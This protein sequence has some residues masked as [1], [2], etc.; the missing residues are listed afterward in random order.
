MS[1]ENKVINVKLRKFDMTNIGDCKVILFIGKRNTGKSQLVLDYLYHNRDIPLGTIISP[2]DDYNFTYK[3]HVPSIFI[4]ENFDKELINHVL[5]RQK[6]MCK[7][8]QF[9]SSYKN[10]DPRAFLIFDDC[11]AGARDWINDKNIRWIFMN[12][13]HA[14]LTFL[15]TMQYPLGIPPNLRTNIDYIFLCKE[16]KI[17]NQK[18][19]YDNYAGIFP[20]FEMFREVLTQCTKDYGCMVINDSSTSN[21]LEDQVFWYR[22][23]MQQKDFDTFKI[24]YPIFWKNN[25]KYFYDNSNNLSDDE[26][27]NN[28]YNFGNNKNM[29]NVKYLNN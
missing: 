24:C 27:D 5:E 13:R 6:D 22:V 20:T 17:N 25:D 23:N 14:K 26:D 15:L 7:K 9:K 8:C 29:Y 16:S 11:L 21:N 2:T 3:P 1:S 12:G 28:K 19:L 4:H 10:I 18:R